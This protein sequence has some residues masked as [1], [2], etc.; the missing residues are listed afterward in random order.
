MEY[1][2]W[3]HHVWSCDIYTHSKV[4]LFLAVQHSFDFFLMEIA[5]LIPFTGISIKTYVFDFKL[6]QIET[7][8]LTTPLPNNFLG[9]LKNA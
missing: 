2:F 1:K 8:A 5:L 3:A 4:R 6:G 7:I 9:S